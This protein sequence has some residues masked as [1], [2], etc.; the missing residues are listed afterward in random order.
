[1]PTSYK[2]LLAF[3]FV[4]LLNISPAQAWD[5][6]RQGFLLG[7]GAGSGNV[8]YTNV[9]SAHLKDTN[10]SDKQGAVAFMPKVG[11]G[12]TD[13]LAFLYYRHPLNFKAENSLGKTE[14]LTAC[15]ELLGFNYYFSDSDSSL[16]IGAGSGNSYF[17]QGLDNQNDTALKG[18]GS[19]YSIGYAFSAHYSIEF[20]SLTGTLD[21]KKGE[22]SGYGV[23]LNVLGY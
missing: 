5:G 1:M 15:V 12:L 7:L 19:A 3:M 16:Y 17:F 8:E 18:T 6:K 20:T 13:Q 22:F 23:T 4:L 14:D 11:Y 10:R 2:V 9:Q 21:E